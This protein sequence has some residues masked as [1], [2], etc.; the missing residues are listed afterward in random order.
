MNWKKIKDKCKE[1]TFG[2]FADFDVQKR[3]F[4]LI[5]QISIVIAI[6]GVIAN[7]VLGLSIVLSLTTILGLLA[8]IY[9]NRQ[10]RK[11]GLK[12]FHTI[13]FFILSVVIFSVLWFYN[14]GYDGNNGVLMFVYF[15]VVIT[16]LPSK[17]R[18]YAF[19]VYGVMILGLVTLQFLNPELITP[20]KF[21]HQ[22][23]IDISVGYFLYLILAY[24]IQNTIIKNYELERETVKQKNDKLNELI[25]QL[26]ET[27]IKLEESIKS[28]EELNSS[29]DRFITVLSH[30][31]RSPFH[32]LLG[33]SKILES[34]YDLFSNQEKKFYLSQMNTSLD[35]LYS[36]LEELLL[37]GR[38]QR[39][40]LKLVFEECSVEKLINSSISPLSISAA[41]KKLSIE[42]KCESDLTFVL[43]K[44]TIS[45][46][47]RNLISNAI[48]FSPIGCK[49]KVTAQK[50]SNELEVSVIDE[51]IGI[52][53]ENLSKL[54]RVDEN[55]ST[56]GTD[57]E[58]GSGMG[59]ILCNDIIKKHNGSI[60]VKSKEGRGS[61]FTITLLNN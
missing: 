12:S 5:T 26:N 61:T 25:N 9:F 37:W 20:Y 17:Y 54:F 16:I 48:K 15:I 10:V 59:L 43:D 53:P 27:N 47:L 4:L 13:G 55:I 34:D 3:V 50:R 32:G 45:I 30:D 6:I 35:K 38:I 23:F 14:G 42:V 58:L 7:V 24:T 11:L 46:V 18:F 31:L 52:T 22:R 49:I 56:Q 39:N 29:K 21:E 44:E 28:V 57:G 36:F 51:G 40:T 19:V 2:N 8:L 60:S 1:I 41:K 33:I